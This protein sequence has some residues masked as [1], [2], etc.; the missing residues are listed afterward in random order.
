MDIGGL[1]VIGDWLLAIGY[2]LLVIGD[3]RLV[4]GYGLYSAEDLQD[5]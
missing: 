1:L 4:M 2:W 5:W 3:W